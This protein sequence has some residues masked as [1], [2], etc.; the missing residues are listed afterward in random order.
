MQDIDL[1]RY[2]DEHPREDP[3]VDIGELLHKD[4][5]ALA[6]QEEVA[7]KFVAAMAEFLSFSTVRDLMKMIGA[8]L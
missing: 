3:F 7:A 1:F 5:E 8:N 4:K 2:Y 6:Y